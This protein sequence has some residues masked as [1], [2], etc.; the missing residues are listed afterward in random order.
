MYPKPLP[1]INMGPNQGNI[2]IDDS[3][4]PRLCD[5]GLSRISTDSQSLGIAVDSSTV[6][7]TGSLRW[8]APELFLSD[9]DGKTSTPNAQTDVYALGCV[10]LEVCFIHIV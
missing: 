5:F 8:M 10:S 6:T 3:G 1:L 4:E 9:Q 2:L 7:G